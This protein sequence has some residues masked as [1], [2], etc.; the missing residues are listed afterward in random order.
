MLSPKICYWKS[1]ETQMCN[2]YK[3][4]SNI[5]RGTYRTF[6]TL[7]NFLKLFM[8]IYI[9]SD[10]VFGPLKSLQNNIC[11]C[12]TA[13][14]QVLGSQGFT[15]FKK[16]RKWS[17]FEVELWTA[18]PEKDWL[19]KKFLPDCHIILTSMFNYLLSVKHEKGRR[20]MEDK[21]ATWRQDF[22]FYIKK[23]PSSHY[24]Y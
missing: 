9:W 13:P 10:I 11:L 23:Q 5:C 8:Y 3:V 6:M 20:K 19:V 2:T 4:E 7:S 1:D 14:G 21:K 22:V 18:I 12:N 17:G 15:S 16:E 24:S